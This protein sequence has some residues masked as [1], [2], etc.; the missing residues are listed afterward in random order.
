MTHSTES[1]MI[2]RLT[3]EPRMP[4]WPIEMPS[5]TAIVTNSIGNPPA[6]RTRSFARFAS[7]SSGMLQGVTSFQLDATPIWG[8]SQSSSVIPIARSIARA[9]ARSM[10]SVTSRLRGRIPS[11]LMGP[12]VMPGIRGQ[13]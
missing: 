3:S 4:S 12:S 13:T 6:S 2:S 10:P 9:G 5:L 7:R 1:V 11:S 8:L